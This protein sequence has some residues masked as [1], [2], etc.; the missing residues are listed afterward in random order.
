MAGRCWN[1]LIHSIMTDDARN[2]FV[3]ETIAVDDSQATTVAM[4]QST[5]VAGQEQ[6]DAAR[7]DA[8]TGVISSDGH[9]S[10][11]GETR[12]KE[13]DGVQTAVDEL[14]EA[15]TT[16][17]EAEMEWQR[18]QLDRAI[19]GHEE[20]LATEEAADAERCEQFQA[21]RARDR[22]NWVLQS[23]MGRAAPVETLLAGFAARTVCGAS[24]G[25]GPA[26]RTGPFGLDD[27]LAGDD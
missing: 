24:R 21:S 9:C 2:R 8:G 22:D 10:D 6:M 17:R 7:T 16:E 11:H 14:L 23:K 3:A 15:E 27:P 19:Q 12:S 26:P 25:A 5:K 4:S 18:M 1:L 20:D 13:M